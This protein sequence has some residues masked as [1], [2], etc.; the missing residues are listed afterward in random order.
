ML[1]H[2]AT[3]GRLGADGAARAIARDAIKDAQRTLGLHEAHAYADARPTQKTWKQTVWDALDK[4][5]AEAAGKGTTKAAKLAK[6]E[7]EGRAARQLVNAH[8]RVVE[9]LAK[10]EEALRSESDA[11]RAI[12]RRTEDLEASRKALAALLAGKAA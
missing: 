7:E 1:D 3:I 4:A 2:N 8:S 10:L 5:K 9:A 11:E 12:V 6:L